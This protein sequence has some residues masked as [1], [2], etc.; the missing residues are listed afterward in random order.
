MIAQDLQEQTTVNLQFYDSSNEAAWNRFVAD[1]SNG[2]FLLNRQFMD[3]HSD[4]FQDASL[5][6]RDGVEIVGLLPASIHNQTVSSH[7]G[8]TYAGLIVGRTHASADKIHLYLLQICNYF[9]SLGVTSLVYKPIPHMYHKTPSEADL[10]GLY[11]LG[12]KIVR[13]DLSSAFA[14]SSKLNMRKGRKALV[15]RAKKNT[16]LSIAKSENWLAFHD[17]LRNRLSEKYE[18][19]PVHSASEMQLLASRFPEN[20]RLITATLED[21][22]IAGCVVFESECV[23][24]TQYLATNETGRETG[25]MDLLLAQLIEAT[26][27]NAKWFDFGISTT[28]H[29]MNLNA[30]LARYKESFGAKSVVY[31]WYKIDL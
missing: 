3:Y 22:L 13:R 25:A 7:A 18:A 14:P 31:D 16:G 26:N 5:I 20:I 24:H 15:Q 27:T 8:L 30:A 17:L 1:S 4:R 21:E 10:H 2:T 23:V 29:G 19:T 11:R 28:D 9:R 12:A 6:I